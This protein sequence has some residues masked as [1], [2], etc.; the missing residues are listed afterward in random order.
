MTKPTGF[1]TPTST[2]LVQTPGVQR[3]R[4]MMDDAKDKPEGIEVRFMAAKFGGSL[5]RAKERAVSLQ[6]QVSSIRARARNT[7]HVRMN[8]KNEEFSGEQIRGQ[9]DDLVCYK[10]LLPGD[11]GYIVVIGPTSAVE[12]DFEIYDRATG[13]RV[14]VGDPRI[15]RRNQLLAFFTERLF[16]KAVNPPYLT[17]EQERE[18]HELDPVAFRD[19][20]EAAGLPLP[21]WVQGFDAL[22]ASA[23]PDVVDTP[24]DDFG[25]G[26]DKH[27]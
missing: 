8:R 18:L 22:T 14:S 13:Q 17:I 15:K 3:V 23:K 9:Y 2:T 7:A 6:N 27:T 21:Q 20:F 10:R 24:M 5:A 12:D 19:A 4:A 1:G 26:P 16:D 25:V 11:D